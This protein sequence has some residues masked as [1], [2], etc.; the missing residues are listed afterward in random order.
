MPAGRLLMAFVALALSA[1][2]LTAGICAG[3][4]RERGANMLTPDDRLAEAMRVCRQGSAA[5][6]QALLDRLRQ[7]DFTTE[8]D[9]PVRYA[10]RQSPP[11][12]ASLLACV[13]ARPGGPEGLLALARE[14]AYARDDRDGSLRRT[15]LLRALGDAAEP[16][17]AVM[18]LLDGELSEGRYRSVAVGALARLATPEAI[19]ILQR[20][21][22]AP[23]TQ[24]VPESTRDIYWRNYSVE[25]ARSRDKPAALALL[26]GDLSRD[27]LEATALQCLAEDTVRLGPDPALW[28]RLAPLDSTTADGPALA[29]LIVDWLAEHGTTAEDAGVLPRV[30]GRVTALLGVTDAAPS[31]GDTDQVRAWGRAVFEKARRE[32]KDPAR[33]SA[34]DGVLARWR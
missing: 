32:T 23:D 17:A 33:R 18:Q 13:A 8:L 16:T 2:V 11:N 34:I 7:A 20:R 31:A 28:F 25:V 3:P 26:L 22:F 24:L 10:N 27:D 12:L 21:I 5:E 29:K 9:E 15:V 30:A 1:V 6:F 19:A 4:A 14:Q